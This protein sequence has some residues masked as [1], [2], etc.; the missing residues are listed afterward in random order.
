[1]SN[2]KLPFWLC[3][4]ENPKILVAAAAWW[5]IV[6]NWLLWPLNQLD[7][8][9][10]EEVILSLHAWARRVSR[11]DGESIELYRKRI[12]FA[13]ANAADSGSTE[14]F[15]AIFE[16][17]EIGYLE[18]DE[19]VD[20]EDFDMVFLTLSDSQLA[21][22]TDLLNQLIREYGRTCRRY[23][24]TTFT[25]INI[26]VALTEFDCDWSYTKFDFEV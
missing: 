18:I 8:K 21:Q 25:D 15:K 19:R 9:K 3:G 11:L 24:L 23:I 1:M 13:Y 2:Q 14:G 4:G 20:G 16:R 5:I 22:N 6:Q 7:A 26:G 17:L 12:I 10:C